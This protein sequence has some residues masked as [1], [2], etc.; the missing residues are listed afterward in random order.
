V[1]RSA[2]KYANIRVPVTRNA[3]A[4][5]CLRRHLLFGIL[6]VLAVLLRSFMPIYY[7]GYFF[8]SDQAIVGLMARRLATFHQF[9]LYYY[10]LNYLLGVQAWIITPFFW[11]FRPSVAVM[12]IPLVALNVLVALWLMLWCR[13][14]LRLSRALSFV[15]ILP[16]LMPPPAVAASLVETAGASIE[17][18]VYVLLLWRLRSRPWLFGALLAFAFLHREFTIFALPAV[19]LV[20]AAS[21]GCSLRDAGRR[22][23][24]AAGGFALVWLIVDDLKGHLAGSSAAMQIVSLGRQLCLEPAVLLRRTASLF[25][26]CLPALAGGLH[27]PLPEFRINSWFVPGHPFVS[28][29]AATVIVIAF[30]GMV[31]LAARPDRESHDTGFGVYLALI[32]FLT[33]CAYPLSC[34]VSPDGPP[35][36]RYVLLALLLPVGCIATFLAHERHPVLRRGVA[37]LVIIWAAANLIDTAS[38][39]GASISDP[40]PNEHRVLTDYLLTHRIRYARAIYWDAYIVDF[41]SRER[42]TVAS[43]DTYRIEEYQRAVAEHAG[44]A[45]TLTR[46]TCGTAG[47]IQVASWCI[48]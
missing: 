38:L 11:L 21:R 16:F 22:I 10:G 6:A 8:D 24:R 20:E 30:V 29:L 14:E 5:S 34:A 42:V 32:G 12:R 40:P 39:I 46:G 9:P 44:A 41:L 4:R 47:G 13:R 2:L 25:S 3:D 31:R 18:F 1:A 35:I 17:P 45:V 36:L 26:K 33:V 15:A 19:V 48:Q 23:V 43:T 28:W 7:E 27:A 37:G